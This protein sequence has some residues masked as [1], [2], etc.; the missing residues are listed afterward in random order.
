MSVRALANMNRGLVL[1]E[2]S[3][4]NGLFLPAAFQNFCVIRADFPP[5]SY[6]TPPVANSTWAFFY[7]C[8][9]PCP[10]YSP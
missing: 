1:T 7:I 2:P 10:V 8:N 9:S 4:Y 3:E 5:P 6:T